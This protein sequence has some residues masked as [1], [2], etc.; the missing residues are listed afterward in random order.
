MKFIGLSRGHHLFD[1][2]FQTVQNFILLE[3]IDVTFEYKTVKVDIVRRVIP[4]F[5][6]VITT[7]LL[8]NNYLFI[9]LFRD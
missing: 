7:A 5:E 3:L 1:L 8:Q 4:T 2:G 9:Y 6:T